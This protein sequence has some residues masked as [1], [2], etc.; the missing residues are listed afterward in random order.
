[1]AV[2]TQEYDYLPEAIVTDCT[3]TPAV[4]LDENFSVPAL[5]CTDNAMWD[6]GA[7]C[8]LVS[9]KIVEALNLQPIGK[10]GLS[11]ASS[12]DYSET[13]IYLVHIA[14]P[15]GQIVKNV[16]AMFTPSQD[17]DFVIGMD[18][19]TQGDFAITSKDQQTVFSFQR[20]AKE[21]IRFE[22]RE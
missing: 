7:T 22:E 19:I 10:G 3:I 9:K 21:H 16:E 11:D 5:F 18:I 12:E 4:V 8:C 15:T 1:M 2:F 13:D 20:P 17:Y 14:L 6:T